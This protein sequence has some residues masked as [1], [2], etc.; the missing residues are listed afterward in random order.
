MESM[1]WKR[2]ILIQFVRQTVEENRTSDQ[3]DGFDL[4]GRRT[5]DVLAHAPGVSLDA[6]FAPE[7]GVTGELDTTDVSNTKDITTGVPVYSVYG[8][9]DA[10]GG[11]RETL[12]KTLTH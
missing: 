2:M 12:S 3:P 11:H 5:I 1:P 7:H 4:Q 6:I 9:S 10:D 8:A